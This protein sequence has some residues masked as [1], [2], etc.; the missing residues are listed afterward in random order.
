LH[1]SEQDAGSREFRAAFADALAVLELS[2]EQFLILQ[3][4]G[5]DPRRLN[6]SELKTAIETVV[7]MAKA[8]LERGKWRGPYWDMPN[9]SEVLE[10]FDRTFE[11]DPVEILAALLGYRP[12][13]LTESEARRRLGE[14]VARA[15]RE[16]AR[17]AI[18]PKGGGGGNDS[19]MLEV[20]LPDEASASRTLRAIALEP[21]K[22][23]AR[24]REGY[25]LWDSPAGWANEGPWGGSLAWLEE[26]ERP[27]PEER[28]ERCNWRGRYPELV[29]LDDGANPE[30]ILVAATPG[31]VGARKALLDRYRVGREAPEPIDHMQATGDTRCA[32][33]GGRG[34][35]VPLSWDPESRR[36]RQPAPAAAHD[37]AP[38]DSLLQAFN[39]LGQLRPVWDLTPGSTDQT[40]HGAAVGDDDDIGGGSRLSAVEEERALAR[41]V[42]SSAVLFK[43]RGRA[44]IEGPR[45][46]ALKRDYEQ[47]PAVL[48]PLPLRQ[49]LAD[50]RFAGSG[51][52]DAE[53]RSAFLK[54][55]AVIFELATFGFPL[56]R[57]AEAIGLSKKRL[58][59][60]PVIKLQSEFL[61]WN[62]RYTVL[63]WSE[64]GYSTQE[65]SYASG[66]PIHTVQRIIRKGR[67]P[68][69]RSL[70]DTPLM[71]LIGKALQY[72]QVLARMELFPQR[73]ARPEH[74][75]DPEVFREEFREGFPI[76]YYERHPPGMPFFREGEAYN[77]YVPGDQERLGA[78]AHGDPR[79]RDVIHPFLFALLARTPLGRPSISKKSIA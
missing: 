8:E 3:A 42:L 73:T 43:K 53:R 32:C 59:N 16:L 50:A 2:H 45:I 70:K 33:C 19:L 21:Q 15:R 78:P 37:E 17:V 64:R 29:G 34:Y 38:S 77:S 36:N 26:Q 60:L 20:P 61:K 9:P 79:S 28:C 55:D 4:F 40:E 31:S 30:R 49:F 62:Q 72:G 57:I 65:I 63:D 68:A 58:Y 11:A 74:L 14:E 10:V 6:A 18:H 46:D 1:T 66:V 12:K 25:W 52:T 22:Q 39:E 44:L 51:H 76:D 56:D 27:E 24:S 5:Y 75:M 23:A 7:G 69:P 13:G 67:E 47:T 54:R 35:Q 48:E 71:K 41:H